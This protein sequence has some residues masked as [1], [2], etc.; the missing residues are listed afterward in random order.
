MFKKKKI[1][2]HTD[3]HRKYSLKAH[4]ILVVKYRKKLLIELGDDIKQIFFDISKDSDFI[5]ENMEV[6]KDHI[7]ILVDYKPNISISA[8][9]NRLKS[10]S[11]KIIWRNHDNYLSKY[12]WKKRVFWSSGWFSCSVGQACLATIQQYIDNQG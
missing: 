5:I 9:V 12:F 6:D 1:F 7:H 2:Y 4:I 3:S 8:I 10:L 11:T